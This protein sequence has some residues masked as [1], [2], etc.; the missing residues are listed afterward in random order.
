MGKFIGE[1]DGEFVRLV[2]STSPL[3]DIGKVGIPDGVLLKPGRLDDRRV[4]IM[5]THT[6]IGSTTLDAALRR[7]PGASS[8]AW[9]GTSPPRTTS[10]M[11]ETAIPRASRARRSRCA[12]D[13]GTGGC[14]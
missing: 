13:C 10:D 9:R 3:H 1:I 7:F 14:V 11:T 5:K 8:C 4:R 6:T 2:Y 12:A